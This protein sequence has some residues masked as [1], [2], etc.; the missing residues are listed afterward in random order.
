MSYID[1][2]NPIMQ[3]IKDIEDEKKTSPVNAVISDNT[4][5]PGISG[6][7]VN[8]H[9]S[10]VKME[11]FGSFNE[12]YLIY[13]TIK[14]D[15]S[16]DDNKDKIIIKGNSAKRNVSLI[17]EENE[18]LES[19]LNE[20]NVDYSIIANLDTDLTIQREYINGEIEEKNFSDLNTILNKNSLNNQI[21]LIN[22]SHYNSCLKKGY[23]LVDSS[24][25]TKDGYLKIINDLD[26]GDIILI[27]KQTSLDNLKLIL[28]EIKKLDLTPVYLS[29]L[30]SE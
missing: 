1:N 14:P 29:E 27:N 20:K 25:N 9:K 6:K 23:Y 5:I 28:S 7:E 3:S 26:S 21:C 13:N 22:Y 16:L 2:K 8:E 24:L 12:T 11:E 19:Y 18:E 10:L 4:I 17:L 30:I 15:I